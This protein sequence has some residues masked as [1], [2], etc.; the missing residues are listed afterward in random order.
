MITSVVNQ[1]GGVGKTTTSINLATA[2]AMAN[3]K[4]LI[5]DFDPQ[6]NSSTSVGIKYNYRDINIYS[7]IVGKHSIREA[8][9]PTVVERLH[10]VTSNIDLSAAEVEFSDKSDKEYILKGV[11][12]DVENEYDYIFIDCPPS[13]GFMTIN[14][15]AASASVIIP[16]QSEF[17]ALEGLRDLLSVISIVKKGLNPNIVI[18][19]IVLTMSDKRNKISTSVE[20]DVRGTL[21]DVVF[22]TVVPRNIR[23]AEAPSYGKPALIYDS[24]CLGSQ[25]Y[26]S[27]AKEL[28]RRRSMCVNNCGLGVLNA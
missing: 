16:M 3:K 5:V 25:A 18:D 12:K 2:L 13:L 24:K 10:I 21:K 15:L 1:K 20:S 17:L 26:M 4:V 23:L 14:A 6:G 22:D 19:G 9:C 7:V 8:I 28:I 27:L 11:L